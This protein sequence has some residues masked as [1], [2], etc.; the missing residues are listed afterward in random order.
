MNNIIKN[1]KENK[2]SLDELKDIAKKYNIKIKTKKNRLKNI[3]NYLSKEYKTYPKIEDKN[4]LK[5]LYQK[6]EF[7]ENRYILPE[8]KGDL[9]KE[10]CPS[11]DKKFKLLSHQ[12]VLRNYMNFNT[13]YN[14]VLVFHGMGSGKTCSSITIAESYKKSLGNTY[15][16]KVLVLVSGDTIEEN[17]RN[18]I[19]NINKGYNQC[20]FSDYINY[21]PYDSEEL[22]KK[23]VENL[24]DKNYEIEHYQK[25]S[26]IL[27]TKKEELNSEEF[28]KWIEQTYSNRVFII[29]EVHNLKIKDKDEKGTIKRYEAVKL[30]ATY[31]KNLK[32]VLLSGTPMSHT[33]KEIVSILNLLLLNDKYESLKIKDI[34]NT[35][36][37]LTKNGIK[38]ISKYSKL[39][40]SY[41][42]KENPF[43]F[44]SKKYSE[45][46][47]YISEFINKKFN[48]NLFPKVK[49]EFKIIP[50]VMK[51]KQKENYINYLSEKKNNIQDII[52]LQ[53]IKYDYKVK[54]SIYNIDFNE[55]T[56]SNIENL[57]SK[58]YQLL[59]NIKKSPGPIFIYTNYKEKGIYMIAS[60]LLKNGININNSRDDK[61]NPLFSKLFRSKRFKP[62]KSKQICS[63]CSN[64]EKEE[65]KNHVFSPMLFDF[66]I[67][68]T[69]EMVQKS[70]INKF[71]DPS[72]VN[73]E[74]LK[75]IIGS[76]VLKEG[77]SFFKVRQLHI[78]EPWHNKSRLEQVIARGMRHCSHKDL[79]EEDRNIS[80]FL[81]CSTLNN[82][83]DNNK[84]KNIIN[85]LQKFF[86]KTTEKKIPIE[87]AKPTENNKEPLLSFDIIMYKRSEVLDYYIKKVEKIIKINAFDCALNKRL[88]IDT[89]KPEEKYMCTGFEEEDYKLDEKDIDLSTY[90]NV[91]LTPYIKY[92]ISIINQ[93]FEKS[94]ILSYKKL[95][96]NINLQEKIYTLNDYYILRKALDTI[97][98]KMDN[99][100]NFQYIMKH[101]NKYGY[102]FVREVENDII[103]IFKE[104]ENQ[105]NFVRSDFEVIPIYEN[106][107]NEYIKKEDNSLIN[108]FNILEKE[109]KEKR[110]EKLY[111]RV[112]TQEK[113]EKKVKKVKEKSALEIIKE[114]DPL[115]NHV[116]DAEYVGI[117]F[118]DRQD[119]KNFKNKLWIRKT[120]KNRNKKDNSNI[121]QYNAGAECYPK[122]EKDIKEIIKDLWKYI[123]EN[124]HKEF[125]NKNKNIYDIITTDIKINL[126]KKSD[127]KYKKKQ[128]LC[129]FI[130]V[131][132]KFLQDK[133]VNNK[134]WFKKLKYY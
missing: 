94:I 14:G 125:Y 114:K 128:G 56:E 85:N 19:H 55:F 30:I 49:T 10:L 87:Y 95:K 58:F 8:V 50:C 108:L 63:I 71:N 82:K 112:L 96:T 116:N 90:D 9:Q 35:K 70:I 5:T 109:N 2:Y 103:Y 13:P 39:Y 59:Q 32:L 75:I 117:I 132:L 80:L 45:D 122:K 37:E 1:I 66:I 133:K 18:E 76:S 88:N 28:K 40:I 33:A 79:K 110:G 81:Y 42:I 7:Y 119:D 92:T 31:S 124:K 27:S 104:F 126:L 41:L 93:L 74:K 62:L 54:K 69:N 67:G 60:M 65:H 91:F 101:K 4:F 61:N 84:N 97:I 21:Q 106:K 100:K 107:Y 98:P 113:I 115:Q 53:L 17:F 99:M 16:N 121:K 23:K 46:S 15:T 47:L 52:Q 29:D 123:D 78:M 118:I 57:S 11:K 83:Y 130:I 12:V 24:I 89:L 36:N 64:L 73:G 38:E 34:F 77:V 22:K 25:L 43:T 86:D 72:N 3:L 105:T 111:Y 44:P 120:S 20:T 68:E 51:D 129:N 102:I 131:L 6:K 48:I 127:K 134:I 26:N